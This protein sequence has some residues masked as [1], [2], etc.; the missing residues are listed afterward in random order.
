MGQGD[1][2]GGEAAGGGTVDGRVE[3]GPAVGGRTGLSRQRK[4]GSWVGGG[5]MGTVPR[6]QVSQGAAL[7]RQ[8]APWET[9]PRLRLS[10]DSS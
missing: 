1:L 8:A 7:L 9:T 4:Q 10:Q 3:S 6:Q 2:V 5:K